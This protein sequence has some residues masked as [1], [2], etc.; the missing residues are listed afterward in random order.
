MFHDVR[1]AF[2]Q[3]R[4]HPAFA[5]L[6]V[7]VLGLGIGAAAAV[8]TIVDGV[9]LK[10]LPFRA[11]DRLVTLWDTNYEKGLRQERVSPVNFMDVRAMHGTFEDAAAWWRPDVNLTDDAL[12]PVRVKTIEVS[13]NLFQL[14]G[15]TPEVGPGFPA[16]GPF[17]DR[18]L[19]VVISDR[20]WRARY[21]ADRTLIGRQIRLNDTP[22]TVVGI[23]PPRFTFPDDVDVWERL[24]WDL[25]Q[26]SRAA[27]FMET[28]ARLAPGITV[29]Q[30]GRD[31]AA[32]ASRL[33]ASFPATNR[34]WST[35]VMPLLE[36]QLGFYRPALLVLLGAVLL[37]MLIGAFNVAGL[38][39]TRSLDRRRELAVRV[40]LGASPL[41]LMRELIA[42]SA[43]LSFVGGSVGLLLAWGLVQVLV[44]TMPV[45]IPRLDQ[46]SLNWR[47][48][49]V[50][51][52][53]I[54]A[55]TLG[56]GLV[57]SLLMMR[58]RRTSTLRDGDRTSTTSGRLAHRSLVVAEVALACALVTASALLV[59]S[60]A[61]LV[62]VPSGVSSAG[63]LT[64]N[65]QLTGPTYGDWKQV[66]AFY[67]S[68]LDQLRQKPGVTAAGA[69]TFL[70][71]ENGWRIAFDIVGRPNPRPEDA[72]IAQH[73]S[74]TDGYF[75]TL[76]MPLVDGRLFTTH[77]T[78]TT[79][80]AVVVNAAFAKQF[81]PGERAVGQHLRSH[82][83]VI[84]PMGRNLLVDQPFEIIGVVG[85]T[86][87]TLPGQPIEP[88][89]FHTTRQ[90]P[91]RSLD[92]TVR[93]ADAAGL[94]AALRSTLRETNSA[95]PLDRVQMLDARFEQ[96]SA[97]PRLLMRLLIAFGVLAVV[98]AVVGI[99]GLLS[100]TV[101]SRKRELAVRLSLGARPVD[102][103]RLVMTHG[104]VLAGAG[105][106]A[107]WLL[108]TAAGPLLSR[109]LFQVS[110]FAP[111]PMAA[112]GLAI[113]VCAAVSTL[114]PAVRASRTDP[115]TVLKSE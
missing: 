91:Y 33:A 83:T 15:V 87:N 20:L 112:G 36:S 4:Q 31:T 26:H 21:N 30:A 41:R 73:F 10:P 115:V 39:L 13:A 1:I 70:P 52:G 96:L 43:V 105:L 5:M 54:T 95:L 32:L 80:A 63:V 2:R 48:A 102:I 103:G 90:F 56:F 49:G 77:D 108:V 72:P 75:E 3:F 61:A 45:A 42:E 16:D 18:Q 69:T 55:M 9:V 114:I 57:P 98:L 8:Y 60:V 7:V 97:Q 37:L 23:M 109:V 88:A 50:V 76:G 12:D 14:L 47:V 107:G 38:L 59:K 81:F 62:A 22:Y 25:T 6:T 66:D 113:L 85:D 17:Y 101:T 67:S 94:Q 82:V 78:V 89:I 53:I 27:H 106:A 65:L 93:G 84:G 51:V 46:V 19:I 68:F 111:A 29:D 71:F 79:Q 86:A 99:Y 64:A 92:I 11:P 110:P 24:Q 28:V 58:Q 40:A 74:V 34:A 104:L 35:R 100:W 44:A